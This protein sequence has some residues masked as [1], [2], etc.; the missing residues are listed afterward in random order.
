MAMAS[1]EQIE[2]VKQTV[3]Q[4]QMRW[5]DLTASVVA[6]VAVVVAPAVAAAEHVDLGDSY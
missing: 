3:D 1:F 4:Q 5:I 2:M 6:S